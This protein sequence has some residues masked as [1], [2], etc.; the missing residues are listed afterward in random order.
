MSTII[1]HK[2]ISIEATACLT[3]FT[4]MDLKDHLIEITGNAKYPF[5]IGVTF[6]DC[7]IIA[8]NM[9]SFESCFFKDCNMTGV[10]E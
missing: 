7:T 8:D 9:L 1:T 4:G 10:K 2:R 5:F 6:R 3:S